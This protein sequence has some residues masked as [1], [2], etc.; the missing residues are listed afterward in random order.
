MKNVY[1]YCEGQSEETFINNLLYPYFSNL[2]INVR[3]ILCTTGTKRNVKYKGG[4][5]TYA[6]IKHEL[7]ILCKNH[8]NEFVTTMFDYYRMPKDTPGIQSDRADLH[9]RIE[10]I[11]NTINQDLGIKNCKFNLVVHEF[12]GLLFSK[13]DAFS[14]IAEQAIVSE[15]KKIR[16][17]FMTP[18]HINNSPETAPSKRLEKLIPGYAKIKNGLLISENIGIDLLLTEC[19]HFSQWIKEIIDICT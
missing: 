7:Q 4:V 9:E 10:L 18:E 8:H 3:P 15:I 6:K 14:L 13:P 12:E 5:T 1:I 19:P 17:S 2:N 11:E 16:A